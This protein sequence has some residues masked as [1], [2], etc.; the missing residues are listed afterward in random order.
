MKSNGR[1]RISEEDKKQLA[2][3]AV[4]DTQPQIESIMG[5]DWFTEFRNA[6]ALEARRA[7]DRGVTDSRDLYAAIMRR[8]NYEKLRKH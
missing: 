2:A 7:I 8:V 5:V 4:L 6:L 1:L 3:T